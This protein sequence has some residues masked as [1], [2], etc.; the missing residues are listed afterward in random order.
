MYNLYSGSNYIELTFPK[1]EIYGTNMLGSLAWD[2]TLV[3]TD[4]FNIIQ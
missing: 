4:F 2:E 3:G 1:I